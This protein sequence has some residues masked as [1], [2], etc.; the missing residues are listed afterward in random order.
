MPTRE[1]EAFEC[2]LD[3]CCRCRHLIGELLQQS[4]FLSADASQSLEE[5]P[6]GSMGLETSD[7]R[8]GERV[9]RYE[10]IR[11]VGAG[12]MG[13]VYEARDPDL[14]RK[15]AVKVLLA[16]PP[17]GANGGDAEARLR[18]EARAMAQLT[19]PNVAAVYD[20]G[21]YRGTTFMVTEYVRGGTLRSWWRREPRSWRHI[22]RML[23][24]AGS[25]L[26]AAHEV[27]VVHR[28]FKPDNILVGIDERPR[29]C[30]FGLACTPVPSSAANQDVVSTGPHATSQ[31]ASLVTRRGTVI[32]T[33]G[34]MSPEQCKGSTADSRSDQYSFCVTLYEGIC[35]V[36]P[37]S[38]ITNSASTRWTDRC[39]QPVPESL[40]SLI[41]R[42]L[43]EDPKRRFENMEELLTQLAPLGT[44]TK[45]H[46]RPR[47]IAASFLAALVLLTGAAAMWWYSRIP[48]E[49]RDSSP[50]LMSGV[51][52]SGGPPQPTFPAAP[53]ATS[54]LGPTATASAMSSALPSS[55]T[56]R[57]RA[58]TPAVV[59]PSPPTHEPVR[60]DS[61]SLSEDLYTRE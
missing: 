8:V 49:A 1:A 37:D 38:E 4:V 16:L 35:G 57:P 61:G 18:R 26:A 23:V 48:T 21:E 45:R 24:E 36:L 15:V 19:H 34:Y 25:G 43:S 39:G 33:P 13:R 17:S 2:H 3:V 55:T 31:H 40:S 7:V 58:M 11:K 27:G 30:D 32:G 6:A 60:D 59:A 9:G 41:I 14:D 52:D 10:I 50:K 54:S 46:M 22:V 29:V 44:G 5:T 51:R 12:G 28:D 47:R 42:G 53:V 56:T 20:V